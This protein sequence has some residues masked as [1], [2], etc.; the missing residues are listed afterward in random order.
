[1]GVSQRNNFMKTPKSIKAIAIIDKNSNKIDIM[2]LY[3]IGDE[4]SITM[5]ILE[6]KAQVEIKFIKWIK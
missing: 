1:M 5:S 2:D 6:K 4:D 3:R